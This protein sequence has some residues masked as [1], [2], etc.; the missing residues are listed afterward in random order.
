MMLLLALI[1]MQV[2]PT[3]GNAH[4]L[5]KILREAGEAGG[6]VAR[7]AGKALDDMGGLSRHLK[8]LPHEADSVA[9]AAHATPEGHWR[10]SNRDGDVFTAANPQEMSRV[11]TNLAP[12]H[13]AEGRLKL[14]VSEESVF[15]RPESLK[16]LP[17]GAELHL[18]ADGRSYRLSKDVASS[19]VGYLAEVKPN[20]SIRLGERALFDEALWHLGRALKRSEIRVVSL[21]PGGP[22]TLSAAPRLETGGQAA[23]IDKIDPWKLPAALRSIRGQTI[24]VTGRVEGEFLHFRAAAGERSLLVDDLK[25]AAKEADVN[26]VL[27][28][29]ADPVQP[30]GRN[31]FWQRVEVPG[32]EKALKKADFADFLDALSQNRQTMVL[33]PRRSLDGRV[34]FSVRPSGASTSTGGGLTDTLTRWTE[35]IFSQ[36][37]GNIVTSGIEADLRDKERQSELDQRIVPGIPST[38][39]FL[40]IAGLVL[41]VVGLSYARAAWAWLWPV[42]ERS[43]YAGA[44]GYHAAR[45]VRLVLFVLVFLPLVGIPVGLWAILKGFAEQVWFF[46][47]LPFRMVRWVWRRIVPEHG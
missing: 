47:T 4:W 13:A 46:V 44:F 24:V 28:E 45:I 5:T 3:S 19:G 29:A 8:S 35:E 22:Q 10:F 6:G 23:L 20:L 15:A 33:E 42:E 32:L 7:H 36:A 34:G 43:E 9:L 2:A 37:V 21:E 27:L 38:L 39:Q 17:A 14:F 26:L 1:G 41:G 18:L 11:I 16:D 40:Y 12:G 31:W 30:G 25:R